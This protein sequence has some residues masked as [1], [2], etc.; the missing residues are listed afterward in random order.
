MDYE[1]AAGNWNYPTAVSAGAGRIAELPAACLELGIRAPLM[2]TDPGIAALPM[3]SRAQ[4]ACIDT[5]LRCEV[6]SDVRGNPTGDN[7]MSGVGAYRGGD[8]DGV[9]AFGGGSALDVAKTVAMMSGQVRPLW[10]F[11]DEGENWTRVREEGVAPVVAVPTT[12]GT[13]SEVGRAAVIT[14]PGSHTKRLIF[15]PL[16]LPRQVILDPTLTAGLPPD[17]TAATGMDALSHNLEAFCARSFHPMADGIALE[18]MRLVREWLPRA[19]A[20]GDDLDARMHM[21]SASSMGATA[22][23][24]G[25][26]AMHALAHPLGALYDAHH[27]LLNAILMPYVLIANR[28]AVADKLGR[29][30]AYLGLGEASFDAFL[31]WILDLREEVGIPASLAEIGIDSGQQE[32]VGQMAALDPTASGNPMPF[33]PSDYQALFARAVA[34]ELP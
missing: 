7:V 12:A 5:G 1:Q 27:G 19:V 23:Q 22:F 13:G 31:A 24:K 3:L 4:Q 9:I 32:R 20:D 34:G 8:H 30:A 14:D 29:A 17:I 6:F 18:G 2:V 25:L 21:L 16:M 26:G 15:H 33:G 28:D 11:V 10:D